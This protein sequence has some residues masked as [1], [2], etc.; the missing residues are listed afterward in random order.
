MLHRG[1][2]CRARLL[3]EAAATRA[4]LLPARTTS[5]PAAGHRYPPSTSPSG[6]FNSVRSGQEGHGHGAGGRSGDRAGA[7]GRKCGWPP[8]TRRRSVHDSRNLSRA[9]AASL[10]GRLRR[11]LTEPVCRQVRQQSG[12]GEGSGK[13]RARSRRRGD[14]GDGDQDQRLTATVTATAAANG[15]QQR[16]ATAHNTRTIRAN[17]GYVRPEKRKVAESAPYTPPS[18]AA[19]RYSSKVQQRPLPATSTSC[20]PHPALAGTADKRPEAPLVRDEEASPV[21]RDIR[22]MI[23]DDVAGG[24]AE[25]PGRSSGGQ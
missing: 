18:R 2:Q 17:W 20:R 12:S 14:L 5:M 16:P 25:G 11:P 10:H 3:V 4:P 19:R 15:Y 21:T 1:R 23:L 7:C 24:R 13:D 6:S 8:R 9:P 22:G